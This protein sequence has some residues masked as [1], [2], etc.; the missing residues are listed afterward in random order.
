MVGLLD[1]YDE[2]NEAEV[3]EYEGYI[4]FS[5]TSKKEQDQF[6]GFGN[7]CGLAEKDKAVEENTTEQ[8]TVVEG[9]EAEEGE[10][11]STPENFTQWVILSKS[12]EIHSESLE[13]HYES[14]EIHS[15]SHVI[16]SESH[17]I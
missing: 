2:W 16:H 8:G 10:I 14:H 6:T 15:E 9:N 1:L 7:D 12:H 3:Q 11:M 17:V 13:I 5:E 4:G